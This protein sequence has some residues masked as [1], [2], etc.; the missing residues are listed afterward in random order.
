MIS[1]FTPLYKNNRK[2][3]TKLI[4]FIKNSRKV[5]FVK[6]TKTGEELKVGKTL[7]AFIFKPS[8][9]NTREFLLNNL[10]INKNIDKDTDFNTF[11][12]DVYSMFLLRK[13]DLSLNNKPIKSFVASLHSGGIT[14]EALIEELSK[15]LIKY[16]RNSTKSKF[17]IENRYEIITMNNVKHSTIFKTDAV[18]LIFK[19]NNALRAPP[20]NVLFRTLRN[21]AA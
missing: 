18:R 20:I 5:G 15:R 9:E 14:K 21:K 2:K 19:D 17:I 12:Q 8:F 3:L 16:V 13:H 1:L 4:S 10:N 11:I 6:V 7:F